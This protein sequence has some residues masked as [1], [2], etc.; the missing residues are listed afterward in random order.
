MVFAMAEDAN[1]ARDFGWFLMSNSKR[2]VGICERARMKYRRA[3]TTTKAVE[4]ASIDWGH[5]KIIVERDRFPETPWLRIGVLLGALADVWFR[6]KNSACQVG[7]RF[8]PRARRS[9]SEFARER[10]SQRSAQD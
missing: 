4:W 2:L 1:R 10:K 5:Y 9:F 6:I 3:Q 8:R 7:S